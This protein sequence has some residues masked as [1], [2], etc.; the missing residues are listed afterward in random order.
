MPLFWRVGSARA[1]V[2]KDGGILDLLLD[3]EAFQ[4]PEGRYFRELY[5]KVT[6]AVQV[7][8]GRAEI[9]LPSAVCYNGY[10]KWKR[11]RYS[12]A[13]PRPVK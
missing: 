7:A 3:A 13:A 9:D 6:G 1:I 8:R 11:L 12:G 4:D 2:G 10:G 5:R